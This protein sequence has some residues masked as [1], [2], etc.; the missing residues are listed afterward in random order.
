MVNTRIEHENLCST[1][2]SRTFKRHT[3]HFYVTVSHLFVHIICVKEDV[4]FPKKW[5]GK[6]HNRLL[7]H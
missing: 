4:T 5:C 2:F 6:A 3:D 7:T 1:V